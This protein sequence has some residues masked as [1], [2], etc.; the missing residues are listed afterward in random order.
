MALLSLGVFG[1][2]AALAME[3]HASPW[4]LGFIDAASP[5]MEDINEFHN[6]LLVIITAITLFVLALLVYVVVKFNEKANPVPS[7][8]THN[9]LLEVAW[10][11]VPILILI[12]IAVPSFKLLFF[13]DRHENPDMTLKVT[14]HQWYW[15]YEYPD[16]GG[17]GFDSNLIEEEDLQ[18]GQ[19]R[20]LA[21]DNE[22]VLP[23]DTNIR[24]LQTS[25]DVFHNW[26]I[27][28]FGLKLDTVPG[29]INENWVRITKPGKY[30]GQCSELCGVRHAFM[31]ITVHAVSKEEFA[32]WVEKAKTEFADAAPE[33]PVKTA[34]VSAVPQNIGPVKIV[35][36][37]TPVFTPAAEFTPAQAFRPAALTVPATDR[38]AAR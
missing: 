33:A 3:G 19:P 4:Q 5:V 31:P 32:A 20:L 27:P 29:R 37:K 15:S 11:G 28:A 1:G 16:H 23:I 8:T 7:K 6:L 34:R 18:P 22:V 21:V 38:N 14:G 2:N 26:A 17:F 9:T 30:Y 36:V 35:D 12:V 13:M 24:V 10:T 25:D